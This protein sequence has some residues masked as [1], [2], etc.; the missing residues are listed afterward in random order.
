MKWIVYTDLLKVAEVE[1]QEDGRLGTVLL[2]DKLE[3]EAGETKTVKCVFCSKLI[4]VRASFYTV[5]IL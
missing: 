5:T 4:G 1:D 2:A 3:L